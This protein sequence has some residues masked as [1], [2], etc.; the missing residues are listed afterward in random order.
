MIKEIALV[1]YILVESGG[2]WMYIPSRYFYAFPTL[3]EC[4]AFKNG[5]LKKE[6]P[7]ETPGPV[8]CRAIE[9]IS[10]ELSEKLGG[11]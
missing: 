4:L 9:V 7:R 1:V 5:A 6:I 11:K 10:K 3:E 2:K 8:E